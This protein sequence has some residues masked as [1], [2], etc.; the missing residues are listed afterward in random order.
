MKIRKPELGE[1]QLVS[2][3]CCGDL[4]VAKSESEGSLD[5][6]NDEGLDLD[7]VTLRKKKNSMQLYK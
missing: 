4:I 6:K 5:S 7:F 2:L 1:G 3:E